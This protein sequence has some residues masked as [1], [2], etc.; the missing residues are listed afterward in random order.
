M[1]EL[2]QHY[3]Y[4]PAM[5]GHYYHHPYNASQ[6]PEQ[7]VMAAQWGEDPRNPYGNELFQHVYADYLA[8][9]AAREPV[10]IVP[11]PPVETTVAPEP[12]E[13]N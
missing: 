5:H 2:P 12:L 3:A 9:Q 7:Q 11:D 10:D 6:L 4:Y 8:E 1:C 13:Q